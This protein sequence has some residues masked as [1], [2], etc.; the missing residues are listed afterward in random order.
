MFCIKINLKSNSIPEKLFSEFGKLKR[1]CFNRLVDGYSSQEAL[2]WFKDNVEYQL[3]RSMLG[4]AMMDAKTM[5][6]SHVALKTKTPVFGGKKNFKLMSEKKI[7]KDEWKKLRNSSILLIGSKCDPHGN[8]KVKLDVENNKLIFKVSKSEHYILEL[9]NFGEKRKKQLLQIQKLA[10]IGECPITYRIKRDS[11]SVSIDENIFKNHNSKIKQDRIASLDLNPNYIALV[12]KDIDKLIHQQIFDLRKLNKIGSTNKKHHELVEVS[13]SISEICK[14]FEVEILGVEQLE[15]KSKDHEKGKYFNKLI[16]NTWNKKLLINNLQKRCNLL[17]IK[18][19]SIAPEYSSFIGCLMNPED[20]DSVAAAKEIERRTRLFVNTFIK[21]T[22]PR[23]TKI[24][25]PEWNGSLMIRWKDELD[26]NPTTW[27]QSYK[28]F[29][30]NPKHSYR[31]LLTDVKNPKLF[32]FKSRK[33]NIFL[34]FY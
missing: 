17:N 27:K 34:C 11:V 3:D 10:D 23:N 18:V 19:L 14:H 25:F 8:R 21:K 2:V 31:V 9:E 33:S 4:S 26:K 28:W 7:T 29:K 15:I 6:S 16:N 1:I 5:Y 24:L 22:L 32:R 30:E 12:I 13:K 20:I